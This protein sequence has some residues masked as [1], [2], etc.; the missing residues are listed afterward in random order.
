[1]NENTPATQD[2]GTGA[3]TGVTVNNGWSVR[4]P[5]SS[6]STPSVELWPGTQ[7]VTIQYHDISGAAGVNL[8]WDAGNANGF[9]TMSD[10][11]F[12]PGLDLLTSSVDPPG[13][14]TEAEYFARR[15]RS[16]L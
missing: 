8:Q 2:W 12:D 1:V 9:V 15:G 3:P 10:A 13:L 4:G 6:T 7:Y 16:A 14:T 5:A 11:T